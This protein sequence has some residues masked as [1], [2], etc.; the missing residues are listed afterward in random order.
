MPEIVMTHSESSV[1][2]STDVTNHIKEL[3]EYMNSADIMPDGFSDSD[4]SLENEGSVYQPISKHTQDVIETEKRLLHTLGLKNELFERRVPLKVYKNKKA[5]EKHDKQ[6]HVRPKSTGT[7]CSIKNKSENQNSDEKTKHESA[8]NDKTHKHDN[9]HPDKTHHHHN[10]HHHQHHHHGK[11]HH[12]Q[13]QH[14]STSHHHESSHEKHQ[15]NHHHH[16]NHHHYHHHEGSHGKEHYGKS[17]QGKHHNE[18]GDQEIS[19]NFDKESTPFDASFFEIISPGQSEEFLHMPLMSPPPKVISESPT[20]SSS[21]YSR[22]IS[23]KFLLAGETIKCNFDENKNNDAKATLLSEQLK[24]TQPVCLCSSYNAYDDAFTGW[25]VPQKGNKTKNCRRKRNMKPGSSDITF[26]R[27]THTMGK[28]PVIFQHYN[29]YSKYIERYRFYHTVGNVGRPLSYSNY[30]EKGVDSDPYY[31]KMKSNLTSAIAGPFYGLAAQLLEEKTGSAS[32]R[33]SAHDRPRSDDDSIE[34][35]S[36]DAR[37]YSMRDR[38]KALNLAPV[39]ECTVPNLRPTDKIDIMQLNKY[40]NLT[41]PPVPSNCIQLNFDEV[42]AKRYGIANESNMFPASSPRRGG[43][44]L[45]LGSAEFVKPGTPD[46]NQKWTV[47]KRGLHR[48]AV[49]SGGSMPGNLFVGSTVW[50]PVPSNTTRAKSGGRMSPYV[51]FQKEHLQN[52]STPPQQVSGQNFKSCER[53]TDLSGKDGKERGKFSY[54]HAANSER[55]PPPVRTATAVDFQE[56]YIPR[57][58]SRT[59][60]LDVNHLGIRGQPYKQRE[61]IVLY[62]NRRAQIA[63]S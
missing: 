37:P 14:Q 42:K 61:Q 24:D 28:D 52:P 33:G 4:E 62:K 23:Y 45:R 27:L 13:T 40:L 26:S 16:R 9:E 21:S 48:S 39:R 34:D 50:S 29:D 11:S 2:C 51:Q 43:R 35:S 60:T 46:A 6:L 36:V 19:D 22:P 7:T 12:H 10:H 17:G 49:T 1:T 55:P 58:R 31:S 47:D 5:E 57:D 53:V 54:T 3:T 18:K 56:T 38:G 44:T 30:A 15:N 59:I 8:H 25:E 63:R 32:S 20:G 41:T